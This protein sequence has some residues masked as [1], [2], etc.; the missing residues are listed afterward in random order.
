MTVYRKPHPNTDARSLLG[1]PLSNFTLKEGYMV[2][3]TNGPMLYFID[4]NVREMN[5]LMV[6]NLGG[7]YQGKQCG[8]IIMTKDDNTGLLLF[9]DGDFLEI[10]KIINITNEAK[11]KEFVKQRALAKLTQAEK[12]ILNINQ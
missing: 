4:L 11:L 10:G 8:C 3:V 2:Q 7:D 12:R 9:V 6:D 5:Q 1:E